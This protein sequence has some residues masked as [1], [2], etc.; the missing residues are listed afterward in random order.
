[1]EGHAKLALK[2]T[3]NWQNK[4]T[5]QSCKVSIPCM[6]DHQFN[7]EEL[8]T[9]RELSKVCSPIVL[10]CPYLARIGGLYIFFGLQTN[11]HEL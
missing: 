10:K 5:E 2:H 1:M 4:K 6:D 9:V 8:K 11:L 7:K 3:A